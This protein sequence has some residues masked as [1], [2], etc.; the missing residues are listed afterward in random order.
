[1]QKGRQRFESTPNTYSPVS[2]V[3]SSVDLIVLVVVVY[4]EHS[5][6][7]GGQEMGVRGG[8]GRINGVV[9]GCSGSSRRGG[10]GTKRQ[11][12]IKRI[13]PSDKLFTS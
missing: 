9:R 8:W 1:M 4:T 6:L 2:F 5:P 3:K 10:N 11:I 13:V 12:K 7:V